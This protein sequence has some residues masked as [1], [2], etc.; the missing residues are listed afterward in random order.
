MSWPATLEVELVISIP[1]KPEV[2]P[3][4]Y[5]SDSYGQL[6]RFG[7]ISACGCFFV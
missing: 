5:A 7:S 2:A 1:R 4:L 3:Y 6:A